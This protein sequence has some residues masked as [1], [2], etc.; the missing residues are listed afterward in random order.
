MLKRLVFLV[1]LAA[2]TLP[3]VAAAKR[4]DVKGQVALRGHGLLRGE[5]QATDPAAQVQL[6]LRVGR[7]RVL[8]LAGDAQVTCNGEAAE[9]RQN[10][11]GQTILFCKGRRARVLLQGS[12]YRLAVLAMQYAMKIPEGVSGTLAGRFRE[13]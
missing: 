12:H 5:L 9:T 2:L 6:R 7:I 10:G 3:A 13:S 8:D 1:L 11:D 4:L